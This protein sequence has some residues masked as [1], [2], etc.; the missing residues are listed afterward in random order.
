M[1]FL[2]QESSYRHLKRRSKGNKERNSNDYSEGC[3]RFRQ[4]AKFKVN[5]VAPIRISSV[6]VE[7]AQ[8]IKV[9][10]A[11]AQK[12]K[13]PTF[14]VQHKKL[15]NGKYYKSSVISGIQT[16]DNKTYTLKLKNA[17]EIEENDIVRVTAVGLVGSSVK[18]ASYSS[19][20]FT[21][22]EEKQYKSN[23]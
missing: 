11:E 9:V 3:G 7:N 23:A 12:L 20:I 10:L 2:K 4:K 18:E 17:E 19:G 22:N 5:V 21:Y 6:N 8:T 13:T 1:E 15:Q 14:S 16:T